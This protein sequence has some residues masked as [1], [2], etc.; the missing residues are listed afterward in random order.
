V[1]VP[2]AAGRVMA[3]LPG[4]TVAARDRGMVAFVQDRD[5]AHHRRAGQGGTT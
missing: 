3:V 4:R 2:G 5:G 1:A